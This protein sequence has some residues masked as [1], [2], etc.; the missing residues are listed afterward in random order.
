MGQRAQKRGF[1]MGYDVINVNDCTRK[2]VFHFDK[3]NLSTEIEQA[4]EKKRSEVTIKGFRKG[5]APL[6]M[7]KNIYLPEI[8]HDAI[9]HFIS[10]KFYDALKEAD[11]RPIGNPEFSNVKL[12]KEDEIHFEVTVETFPDFE[13]KDV[14]HL[15]FEKEKIT[16]TEEE[17]VE[18]RK[19]MLESKAQMVPVEGDNL[20]LDK[21]Q[22]AVF[23]FQG[24]LEN[25]DKPENMKG[26]EYMLEIGSGQFIPG[27]EEGMIGLKV[28]EKKDVNV[29]FPE[30]YHEASLQSKPVVFHVE[31]LEIKEKKLPELTEEFLKE[32]GFKS[33]EDLTEKVKGQIESQK[34]QM[35][36]EKL[37]EDVLKKL[38]EEFEFS[39]PQYLLNEQKK[40]VEKNILGNL[41]RQGLPQDKHAEYIE[42]WGKDLEEKALFQVRTG[43]II[44]KFAEK[45]N[46]TV[47]EKDFEDKMKEMAE[48][49]GM[50]VEDI[51]GY[52]GKNEQL[53]KNYMYTLRE[54]KIFEK[55]LSEVKVVE[56]EKATVKDEE[57]AKD[58]KKEK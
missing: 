45:Y 33:E 54:E 36:K 1:V 10:N 43:L 35:I 31:L 15:K 40:S 12:D 27:F 23:N 55:V 37:K 13:L 53:K 5:K 26:E 56:V 7:V 34:T 46:V 57:E 2:L 24:E 8:K 3:M 52:Y 19:R 58:S 20:V 4:L 32:L 18:S 17:V 21:G 42:K 50:K 38:S 30:T 44:E 9:N 48:Q 47:D 39:V 28:G 51:M 49:S 14:S 25:G 6:Q 29:V 41:E 11:I 16:V 22:F